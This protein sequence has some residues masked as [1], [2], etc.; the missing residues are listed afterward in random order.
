MKWMLPLVLL[1]TACGPNQVTMTTTSTTT[2]EQSAVASA[3]LNEEQKAVVGQPFAQSRPV[4]P[5]DVRIIPPNSLYTQEYQ[6]QRVNVNV[7]EDYTITRV[8]CG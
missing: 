8:W 3:C 1:L 5:A 4:L 2:P 6:P 7:T